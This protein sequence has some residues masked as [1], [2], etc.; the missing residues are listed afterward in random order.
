MRRVAMLCGPAALLE[1]LQH[2]VKVFEF[3]IDDVRHLATEVPIFN[4]LE[5]QVHGGTRRLLLAVR[6]VDQQDIKVILHLLDP[7]VRGC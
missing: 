7:A 4:V 3:L 5:Q 2:H 1:N 6:V